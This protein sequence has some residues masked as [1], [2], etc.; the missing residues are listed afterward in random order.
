ME[1]EPLALAVRVTDTTRQ[2]L[3]WPGNLVT[4]KYYP[5]LPISFLQLMESCILRRRNAPD[6][7][8]DLD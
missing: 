3:A 1:L 8:A 4:G 5:T 2:T 6:D 7:F